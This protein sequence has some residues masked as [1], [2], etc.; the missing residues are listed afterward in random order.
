M[1]TTM[2]VNEEWDASD[3]ERTR[4]KKR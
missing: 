2:L 3:V 4:K 1:K